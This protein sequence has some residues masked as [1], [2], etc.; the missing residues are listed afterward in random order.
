MSQKDIDIC[1]TCDLA[2]H[3]DHPNYPA[4]EA[5]HQHL[6]ATYSEATA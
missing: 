4:I 6:R 3:A 2:P 1:V 5:I